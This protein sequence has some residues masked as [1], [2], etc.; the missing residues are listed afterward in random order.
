MP[1]FGLEDPLARKALLLMAPRAVGLGASQITFVVITIL[2]TGLQTG[3]LSAFNL[4]ML[5]L[6][7]PL[8]VIGVPLGIVL[9]PA[10][11][12]ELA[13]GTVARFL[14]M[15][16]RAL[17]LLVFVML[18]IAAIGMVLRREIVDLLFQY[19][20]FDEAAV[21]MTAAVLFV[22]L[23]GLTAHSMIAVLA[24]SFY[25]EQDTLTP[26]I[27]AISAV[28]VNV[29][30]AYLAVGPYGLDGLAF[31]IAAGAWL[32]ASILLVR[33]VASPPRHRDVKPGAHLRAVAAIGDRGG[34]ARARHADGPRR[35]TPRRCGQ[36]RRARA[37]RHRRGD[38]RARIPRDERGPA[39]PGAARARRGCNRSRPAPARRMTAGPEAPRP[40]PAALR[41][42]PTAW[43]A[44]VESAPTGAYTQLS[45]WAEVKQPN[46]WRA[47]RV[48]AA[49]TGGPIGMQLLVRD[50]RPSPWR[51]GYAPRGP[52]GAFDR[53]AVA[54]LT[55][56]VRRVAREQRIVHVLI[57]PEVETSHPVVGELAAA[58]WTESVGVQTPRTR[59]VDLARPEEEL[60]SDLRSKWR[61]YVNKARR[62]GVT[63]DDVGATG[64]DDFYRIYVGTA[65]RAG[66]IHRARSAYEDVFGAF[67]RGGRARLLMARLADGTPAA[68]LMLLQ[69]G[70]RVIEPYGGM[71]EAGA[72]SRAN[73]LLKWEAIRSSRERGFAL[74]DMW[75]LSHAGIEQFKAG[76]GGREVTYVGGRALV[77][78]RLGSAALGIARKV[79]VARA[80]RRHG[81]A[82]GGDAT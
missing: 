46:G 72:D 30:V 61:Q 74:Y 38:R 23:I 13:T 32:E 65:E 66:F 77:V 63:V 1:H 11:A 25:A 16:G 22:L 34:G 12:T 33:V 3:A 52:L 31:A 57:D 54:A 64:L 42:D 49:G 58:G 78:D 18:P 28:V 41:E 19:A 4:G 26:V 68:T 56:E 35:A 8:G 20:N 17:R 80:R 5:L 10:L 2:A 7:I 69:C 36:A 59:L 40:D 44:F 71:T 37:D 79:S 43:D 29:T 15:V 39:C 21:Q 27:A 47:E 75:G 9:L 50:L 6:Q 45:A 14:G 53:A 73:Y 51:V 62:E 76:F 70:Q 82:G 81:L 48:V 24:R 60:W 55:A 67:D